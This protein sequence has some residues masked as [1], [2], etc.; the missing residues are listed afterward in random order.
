MIR[1][2][3]YNVTEIVHQSPR[4]AVYRA[5]RESDNARVALKVLDPAFPAPDE[6]ARLNREYAIA[7]HLD[8]PGIIGVY[9]LERIGDT[10]MIV[11]EDIGGESIAAAIKFSRPALAEAL[12]LS[13]GIAEAIEGMHRA[14]VIHK[15]INPSNIVWNRNTGTIRII[16]FGTA[17]LL[18]R[19]RSY[20]KNPNILEGTLAYL[21]PE[22]TGRLNRSIDYR[23]DY[24]SL[25]VT[26][27]ELFTGQRPFSAIEPLEMIH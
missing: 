27:Y 10:C 3:G 1:I 21:S 25:G 8:A 23:T 19:E 16:D 11:M 4:T 13:I 22:Q 20:I 12:R 18:P 17:S 14:N 2:P 15:N 6:I 24:Y 9:G 26:L 5:Y 7:R